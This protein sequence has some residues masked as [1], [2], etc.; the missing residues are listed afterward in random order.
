M[1]YF[2]RHFLNFVI[3]TKLIGN[4]A[5]KEDQKNLAAGK[6]TEQRAFLI[7]LFTLLFKTST[8]SMKINH[9][10]FFWVTVF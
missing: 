1:K 2:V 9:A 5:N 4:L 8:F 7:I 10:D 6:G 3:D